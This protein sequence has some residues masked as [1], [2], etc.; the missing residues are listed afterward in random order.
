MLEN[1]IKYQIVTD[2]LVGKEIKVLS[3]GEWFIG[4]KEYF[5]TILEEYEIMFPNR[6]HLK[7]RLW[8]CSG[9]SFVRKFL[10]RCK[11]LLF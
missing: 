8:R 11:L 1:N 6:L 4:D 10:K 2:A 3:E 5:N 7:R 9:H